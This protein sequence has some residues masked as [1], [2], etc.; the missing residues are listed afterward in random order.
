MVLG[1]VEVLMLLGIK[2]HIRGKE[3]REY[4]EE[5]FSIISR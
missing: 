5:V 2:A 4:C 3:L 1:A